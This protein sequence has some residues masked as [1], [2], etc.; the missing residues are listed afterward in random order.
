MPG[1]RG[2]HQG[3]RRMTILIMVISLRARRMEA[4]PVRRLLAQPCH[5]HTSHKGGSQH[6]VA[7]EAHDANFHNVKEFWR[8]E[9]L[10]LH[11][12][13][14]ARHCFLVQEAKASLEALVANYEQQPQPVGHACTCS[15]GPT[16]VRSHSSVAFDLTNTG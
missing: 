6:A 10:R 11:P 12:F 4:Q 13:F 7:A 15:G 3:C 2:P 8:A 5:K 9:F 16:W 1:K 14:A